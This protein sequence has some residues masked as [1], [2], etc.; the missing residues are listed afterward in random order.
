M[1]QYGET[2]EGKIAKA[3]QKYVIINLAEDFFIL[4]TCIPDIEVGLDREM[5]LKG[6]EIK[7][8]SAI[9]YLKN[10]DLGVNANECILKLLTLRYRDF[11]FY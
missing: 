10:A 3:N 4:A 11:E 9:H 6:T 8:E 7:H 2:L 5:L 1:T